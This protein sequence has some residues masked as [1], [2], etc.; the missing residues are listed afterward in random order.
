[1]SDDRVEVYFVF[2]APLTSGF[3]ERLLTEWVQSGC[4]SSSHNDDRIFTVDN[5]LGSTC[6]GEATL[7]TTA[8]TLAESKHA[9]VDLSYQDLSVTLAKNEVADTQPDCPHFSILIWNS[10]F[11]EQGSESNRDVRNRIDQLISLV[12]LLFEITDCIFAYGK[13]GRIKEEDHPTISDL[14][15]RNPTLLTWLNVYSSEMVN[16]LNELRLEQLPWWGYWELEDGGAIGL[17]TPKPIEFGELNESVRTIAEE[18]SL[19]L[20]Q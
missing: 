14:S 18:L 7:E 2:D 16:N 3:F 17:S 13:L 11:K 5:H 1:M 19:P 9:S 20:V 12:E 10:Q 6:G 15:V 8:D 4:K